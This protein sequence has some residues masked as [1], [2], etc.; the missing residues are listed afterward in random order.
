MWQEREGAHGLFVRAGRFLP[1]Y[2]LRLAEHPVFTRRYGGSPL[3]GEAYGLALEYIDP[4]WELHATGF[5][6]D[7][8]LT[9]SVEK[10]DGAA[11]YAELRASETTALGLEGKLVG[12]PD[13]MRVYRGL[14]RRDVRRHVAARLAGS[15]LDAARRRANLRIAQRMARCTGGQSRGSCESAASRNFVGRAR[16]ALGVGC[17][18]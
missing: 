6:H 15:P 8:L 10:G 11:L 12:G 9:D 4:R 1:V 3:Y 5:L 16:C 14:A 7:R 17:P 13:D 18:A 2:G